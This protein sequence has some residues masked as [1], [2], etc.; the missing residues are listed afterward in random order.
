MEQPIQ[1]GSNSGIAVCL[2]TL[3]SNFTTI[4]NANSSFHAV[5]VALVSYRCLFL[6][7]Y[8]C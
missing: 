5:F 1:S 2:T 6:F 8:S 3:F 7:S 4:T